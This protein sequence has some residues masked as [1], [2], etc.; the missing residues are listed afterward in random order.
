MK[1]NFLFSRIYIFF[2][3]EL[4]R[5]ETWKVGSLKNVNLNL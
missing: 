3:G 4:P 1:K 2:G 5:T